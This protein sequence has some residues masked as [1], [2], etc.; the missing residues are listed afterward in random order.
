MRDVPFNSYEI[1]GPLFNIQRCTDPNAVSAVYL[2]HYLCL[3]GFTEDTALIKC[4]HFR[5]GN[6][7]LETPA[8][9][10][11]FYITLENPTFS[12]LG[13]FLS[14]R[15][16]IPIHGIVL[17]Y[18]SI[19]CRGEPE[20][21]YKIHLYVLPYS[22][23]AEEELDKENKK[24]GFQRIKKHEHTDAVYTKIK[25]L[26][27]G[28]PGVSAHPKTL[29]FA[30]EPYQ[31]TEIRLKETIVDI[32]LCVSEEKTED[33]V[34]DTHLTQSDLKNITHLLS[35]ITIH[36]VAG[37][38]PLPEHFVDRHRQALIERTSHISPVLDN[39]LSQRL[40]T[41]EQYDTVR[42]RKPPQEAMRQLYVYMTMWGDNGKEKFYQALKMN[43]KPL[44]RDLETRET[45]QL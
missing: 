5:D 15:K 7:T 44:I 25:Y 34:W 28:R 21:E 37:A 8:Q 1:L 31:F 16:K 40:L 26:I 13:P 33:A 11:P 23:H 22:T 32:L 14:L 30:L 39:L 20:E 10:E 2:P 9:I 35:Q 41:Q 38:S 3:K 36:E 12:C 42:S 45:V 18:F 43:N 24:F 27:T 17:I 29:K 6:V 19:L 4:A